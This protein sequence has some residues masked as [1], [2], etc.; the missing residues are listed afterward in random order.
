M[1]ESTESI[2]QALLGDGDLEALLPAY[3]ARE[4][5]FEELRVTVGTG[6]RV[7]AASRAALD[8]MHELDSEILALGFSRA[9]AIRNEQ[10]AL[11]RRRS[12]I[13]AHG[14]RERIEPK[15]LTIKA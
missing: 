11:R 13:K 15:V 2:H 5:A 3:E 12:A 1:L 9:D 8:R 4:S 6:A 14:S 7:D 10:Q